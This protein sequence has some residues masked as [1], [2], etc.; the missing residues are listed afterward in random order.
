MAVLLGL[1][2]V[3]FMLSIEIVQTVGQGNYKSMTP[4]QVTHGEEFI[5]VNFAATITKHRDDIG[6]S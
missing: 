1:H 3:G 2:P 4:P 5:E 6:R